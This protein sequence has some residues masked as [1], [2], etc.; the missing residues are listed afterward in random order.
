MDKGGD[1]ARRG[2]PASGREAAEAR[3]REQPSGSPA[4]GL[5]SSAGRRPGSHPPQSALCPRWI[6]AERGSPRRS[7]C[8]TWTYFPVIVGWQL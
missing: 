7:A 6:R 3:S 4:P 5:L 8:S 1:G 2:R